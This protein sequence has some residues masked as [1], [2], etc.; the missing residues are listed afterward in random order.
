MSTSPRPQSDPDPVREGA[1]ARAACLLRYRALE[2]RYRSEA[3][4]DGG[5]LVG[6][7]DHRHTSRL[8]REV[9][10]EVEGAED[11]ISRS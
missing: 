11:E 9:A 2:H 10:D 6:F 8:E 4:L 3:A 7:Q 1:A 5:D